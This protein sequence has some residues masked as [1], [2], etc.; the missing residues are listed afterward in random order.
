MLSSDADRR[1]RRR[2]LDVRV[3]VNTALDGRV[4]AVSGRSCD[5]SPGG[6]G[7]ILTRALPHGAPVII[8]LRGRGRELDLPAVLRHCRGFRCGFQFR[9]LSAQAHRLVRQLHAALPD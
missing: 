8:T 9:A 7:T 3:S 6:L 5:L 2:C 4:L 1:W